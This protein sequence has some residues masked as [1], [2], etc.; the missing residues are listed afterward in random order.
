MNPCI[1]TVSPWYPLSQHTHIRGAGGG[2]GGGGQDPGG[3]G[4]EGKGR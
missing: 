2:G 4:G 3:D 1:V